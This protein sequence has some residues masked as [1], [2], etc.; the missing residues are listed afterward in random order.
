[1][2]L[3]VR[4]KRDCELAECFF[5]QRRCVTEVFGRETVLARER[6]VWRCSGG[7]VE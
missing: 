6:T 7:G 5:E 1:M 2:C 3:S 4:Q